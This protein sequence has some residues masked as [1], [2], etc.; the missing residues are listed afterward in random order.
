MAAD[1]SLHAAQSRKPPPMPSAAQPGH[2]SRC[3]ITRTPITDACRARSAIAP[4]RRR[5]TS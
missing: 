4:Y 3:I 1:E 2:A 5:Q